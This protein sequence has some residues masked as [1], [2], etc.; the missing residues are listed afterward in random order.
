[1]LSGPCTSLTVLAIVRDITFAQLER[2]QTIVEDV[3][4]AEGNEGVR[5]IVRLL[6]EYA[7]LDIGEKECAVQ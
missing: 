3:T 1:M 5:S 6:K 2:E 4:A 7:K